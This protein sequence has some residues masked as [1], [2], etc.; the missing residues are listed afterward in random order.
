MEIWPFPLPLFL[1]PPAVSEAQK[2]RSHIRGKASPSPSVTRVEVWLLLHT[3]VRLKK[4]DHS[5]AREVYVSDTK[6]VNRS[7]RQMD[8]MNKWLGFSLSSQSQPPLALPLPFLSHSQAISDPATVDDGD[9]SGNIT[10]FTH[11]LT[12]FFDL[13]N[14]IYVYDLDDR[15]M[16]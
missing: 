5:C 11:S 3:S 16:K 14:L 4:V 13:L 10:K 7:K 8:S 9:V 1:L 12:F 2:H 15:W 6:K